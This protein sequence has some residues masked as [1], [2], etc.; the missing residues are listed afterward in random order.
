MFLL[1][2]LFV[3]GAG[4]NAE[5]GMP[6]GTVLKEQIAKAVDFRRGAE[7]GLLIGDGNLYD[8]I[9]DR[10][11]TEPD[12]YHNGGIEL[13]Q[14][15]AEFASID[16]ALHWF[17]GRAEIVSLGKVCIVRNI[18]A[19]EA[20][21]KLAKVERFTATNTAFPEV[22]AT[23][24]LSMAIGSLKKGEVEEAFSKVTI[25]NFNYDRAIE[26]FLFL[27][28][29]TQF[30]LT[31]AEAVRAI[32]KLKIIRPY[33]AVAPLPWQPGGTDVSFGAE[34]GKDHEK[35]FAIAENIKTYTEQA[36]AHVQPE[37]QAAIQ[38]SRVIVILGFGFHQQNMVLLKAASPDG[39]RIFA[40]VLDID[41]ENYENLARNIA[42]TFQSNGFPPQ[43]IDRRS[44]KFLQT[45]RP[46]IMAAV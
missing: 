35:L 44:Y 13:S 1:P 10:F 4:A 25:I 8:L 3:I 26:H 33:G 19:A 11:R 43:L 21:S 27:T 46:S 2:T 22:W 20:R 40:T 45:M 23:E 37:I 36:N 7:N 5:F 24:F 12:V 34:F 32:L 15:M 41:R 31:E 6:T 42:N 30:K 28:L 38:R 9:G 14:L 18:L 16:E 39:K 29:T 17:S